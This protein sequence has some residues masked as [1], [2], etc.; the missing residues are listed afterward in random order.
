MVLADH[1][2]A[3]SSL[4]GR[5][6]VVHII[7]VPKVVTALCLYL[8]ST[9]C[10]QEVVVVA[11]RPL[12]TQ[13][14]QLVSRHRSQTLQVMPEAWEVIIMEAVAAVVELEA[15]VE[16]EALEALQRRRGWW[17]MVMAM[18]RWVVA[19]FCGVAGVAFTCGV[20]PQSCQSAAARPPARAAQRARAHRT[21]R[22]SAQRPTAL[23]ARR[24]CTAGATRGSSRGSSTPQRTTEPRTGTDCALVSPCVACA[25]TLCGG[26][27]LC[28]AVSAWAT[29]GSTA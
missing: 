26:I 27:S 23:L 5:D 9:Y 6:G 3:V 17:W 22:A 11:R 16:R 18:P 10:M 24:S 20:S 2:L 21:A 14:A 13:A 25:R 19:W 7:M 28:A 8:V 12:T 29:R 4:L 15:T 1:V